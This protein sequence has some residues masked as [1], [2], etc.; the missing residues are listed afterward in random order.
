MHLN[1]LTVYEYL[2]TRVNPCKLTVQQD[3]TVIRCPYCG[4]S[5][6]ST[7][8][9]HLYIKN[10]APFPYYCQKCTS[11]GVVDGKFLAVLEAYD[12]QVDKY[13]RS[14]Q[15]EYQANLG[16][17]YGTSLS[18]YVKKKSL[19][20]LP[21]QYGAAELQKLAYLNHRLGIDLTEED[22]TTFSIVLNV[23]D[24]MATNGL[25]VQKL[26]YKQR[27]MLPLLDESYV[28][29]LMSDHQMINARHMNPDSK[30]NK[31]YKLRFFNNLLNS[32]KPSYYAIQCPLDLGSEVF[33]VH[34][35]E[36]IFDI[37]SVY[38]HIHKRPQA[39]NHI[40]IANNGKGYLAV[41]NHLQKLGILNCNIHIY[42][43]TD[44][45]VAHLTKV[46]KRSLLARFN[47]VQVYYNVYQATDDVV[48]KDF[49]VRPEYIQCSA[50][51]S[52]DFT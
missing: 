19:D 8:S 38:L 17:R 5:V 34:L 36:G 22:L 37:L 15:Y 12:S 44:V 28:M 27:E 32:E 42:S 23:K 52:I 50:P 2:K 33:E 21:H 26:N 25:D 29:F 39:R 43:D 40:F 47:G 30:A 16:K 10:T 35:A 49:G 14:A 51:I 46:L 31:F 41:L 3:E 4:D 20:I 1:D 6:K 45:T 7:M 11:A 13:L 18:T 9:A 48:I 24:F